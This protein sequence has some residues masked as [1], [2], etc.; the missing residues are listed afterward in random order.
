MYDGF[1]SQP[2]YIIF[3]IITLTRKRYK[4]NNKR[5][6]QLYIMEVYMLAV[7]V[8]NKKW[9]YDTKKETS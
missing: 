4:I 5:N 1:G 8:Y 9:H 7:Q 2:I 6:I 3:E